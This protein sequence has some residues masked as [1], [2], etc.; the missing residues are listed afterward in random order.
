LVGVIFFTLRI[1]WSESA[2]DHIF[3]PCFQH[4]LWDGC[5]EEYKIYRCW[6]EDLEGPIPGTRYH[7]NRFSRLLYAESKDGLTWEK[8]EFDIHLYDGKKQTS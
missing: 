2:A 8:P 6:Y 7:F 1:L 4:F 3:L 5:D